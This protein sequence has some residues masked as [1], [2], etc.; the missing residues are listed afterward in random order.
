LSSKGAER[1]ACTGGELEQAQ[2]G[3]PILSGDRWRRSGVGA[4]GRLREP[5]AHPSFS[6]R[7]CHYHPADTPTSRDEAG[8]G[9]TSPTSLQACR[10]AALRSCGKGAEELRRGAF[11]I[12]LPTSGR[13]EVRRG[14]AGQ[15]AESC[16]PSPNA[17]DAVRP[18]RRLLAAMSHHVHHL[19]HADAVGTSS[20]H[21]PCAVAGESGKIASALAFQLPYGPPAATSA[22][23]IGGSALVSPRDDRG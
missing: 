5:G 17:A 6:R 22:N 19:S 12:G 23:G 13:N 11:A 9:A 20:P 2:C 4:Q 7:S 8:S 3:L 16:M 14:D 1:A 10:L 18:P 15:R 21:R